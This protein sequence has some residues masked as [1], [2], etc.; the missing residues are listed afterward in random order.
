MR[1]GHAVGLGGLSATLPHI[2][3]VTTASADR[4]CRDANTG[5]GR[6]EGVYT[7]RRDQ[8]SMACVALVDRSRSTEGVY[9]WR[10]QAAMS[11]PW[12]S[13]DNAST[14]GASELH[15]GP[16]WRLGLGPVSPERSF[17]KELIG[18]SLRLVALGARDGSRRSGAGCTAQETA[19]SCL[20]SI[21]HTWGPAGFQNVCLRCVYRRLR[22]CPEAPPAV[23]M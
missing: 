10:D 9:K 17:K 6:T 8:V 7:G 23:M 21:S 3:V 12:A 5:G 1:H 15:S 14:G 4:A 2:I 18:T 19:S 11:W 13:Q 16:F 22:V 20:V